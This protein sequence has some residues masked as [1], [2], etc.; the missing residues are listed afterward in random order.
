M[1]FLFKRLRV[2]DDG[3]IHLLGTGSEAGVTGVEWPQDY[4][5]GNWTWYLTDSP[6]G[7]RG[8][9]LPSSGLEEAQSCH[10]WV[11]RR[12]LEQKGGTEGGQTG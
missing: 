3:R 7:G 9:I 10:A 12:H 2:S 4:K 6:F 1:R 5:Q 11:A 8:K